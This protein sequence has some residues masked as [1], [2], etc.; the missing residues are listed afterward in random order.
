MHVEI[1]TDP[2]RRVDDMPKLETDG[3]V[4]SWSDV[5][6]LLV[7]G[8]F[9]TAGGDDAVA[10]TRKWKVRLAAQG[11]DERAGSGSAVVGPEIGIGGGRDSM[12]D[13]P[14]RERLS[15]IEIPHPHVRFA[16]GKHGELE[17][18]VVPRHPL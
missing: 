4:R 11:I 1:A 17:L 10:T 9:G 18:A 16:A 5:D 13:E 12:N 14:R 3:N 6:G 2:P 15:G 8:V 7:D